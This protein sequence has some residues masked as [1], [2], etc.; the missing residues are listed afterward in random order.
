MI[1]KDVV[2]GVDAHKRIY[3]GLQKLAKTV[4]STFGPNGHSV[5]LQKDDGNLHCTKDGVTVAR[6][7]T[8]ADQIE[9][10][11]STY[12]KDIAN[13]T[14]SRAGDGTTT[15]ILLAW[16]LYKRGRNEYGEPILNITPKLRNELKE[17][18]KKAIEFLTKLAIPAKDPETLEK[19]AL[20]ASNNDKEI[21]SLLKEAIEVIGETGNIYVEPSKSTQTK[22]FTSPGMGILKG[23]MS[24]YFVNNPQ[25]MNSELL[26]PFVL[27][28]EDEI[29][30]VF[31]L[32]NLA[33]QITEYHQS[34]RASNDDLGGKLTDVPHL[35]IVCKKIKDDILEWVITQHLHRSL[36]ICVIQADHLGD[37]DQALED[38]MTD[39]RLIT[40]CEGIGSKFTKRLGTGTQQA[41]ISDLGRL[42]KSIVTQDK[43][44]FIPLPKN[45]ERMRET[46]EGLKAQLAS[47]T[48]ETLRAIYRHRISRLS[49]GVAILSIGGA[50]EKSVNERTDRIEDAVCAV[51]VAREHGVLP[52]GGLPYMA[53]ASTLSDHK[54]Q[55]GYGLFIEALVNMVSNLFVI[56]H[57]EENL[58]QFLNDCEPYGCEGQNPKNWIGTDL[59]EGTPQ[60]NMYDAGILEPVKVI[61]EAIQNATDII[62]MLLNTEEFVIYA[63]NQDKKFIYPVNPRNPFMG[64]A[65]GMGIGGMGNP[66]MSMMKGF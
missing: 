16:E 55:Q 38:F 18:S 37:N 48:D 9:Y 10:C 43:S 57:N 61:I 19:V 8:F 34:L 20:V 4:G 24:S 27:I 35:L 45:A 66:A 17:A 28:T 25:R 51:M 1:I 59:R 58:E 6:E 53:V 13:N 23:F 63:D 11:G 56:N 31:Q 36:N 15:A 5:S 64:G 54:D 42:H 32:S 52:G 50:T 26:L 21:A 44:I 3:S 7:L 49:D 41:N 12:I 62:S 29:Y 40:G 60:V 22:L 47:E 33:H 2:S 39:L 65:A 46:S 30:S 14:V